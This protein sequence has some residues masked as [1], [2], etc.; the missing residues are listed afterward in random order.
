VELAHYI[1]EAARRQQASNDRM[2]KAI[3]VTQQVSDQL[4]SGATAANRSAG[5]LEQVVDDLQHVVGGRHT[6]E[7][8]IPAGVG[9]AQMGQMQPVGTMTP[10]RPGGQMMGQMGPMGGQMGGQM[11]RAPQAP[12]HFGQPG[13]QMGGPNGPMGQRGPASQM[14]PMGGQM[15]GQMGGPP[16]RRGGPPS[17]VYRNPPSQFG[18][19]DGYPPDGYSGYPQGGPRSRAMPDDQWGAPAGAGWDD[20]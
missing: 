15:G 20:R 11:M 5:Q 16:S 6:N 9:H 12:T 4:V 18:P 10:T 8:P 19:P 1:D 14:G 2:D 7:T 13:G 3:M 17:R